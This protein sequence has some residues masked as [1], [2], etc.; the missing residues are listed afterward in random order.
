MVKTA[1]K[2]EA[3]ESARG[4]QYADRLIGEGTPAKEA[5]QMAQVS[6][7]AYYKW[8]KHNI[9]YVFFYGSLRCGQEGYIELE[10]DRYLKYHGKDSVPGELYDLG[11]Y[12]GMKPA[13]AAAPGEI[14]GELYQIE[15]EGV[16]RVLD[17]FERYVPRSKSLYLRKTVTTTKHELRAWAYIYAG[18]VSRKRLIEAGDWIRYKNGE[19]L[20]S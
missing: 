9:H 11:R 2:A 3:P 20:A 14:K 12:P 17:E 13:K 10:L 16:L 4:Y 7:S 5:F 19:P 15:D 6:P 8:R 18:R 1:N